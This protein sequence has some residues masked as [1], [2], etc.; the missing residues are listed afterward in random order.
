VTQNQ[1]TGDQDEHYRGDHDDKIKGTSREKTRE[2]GRRTMYINYFCTFCYFQ[3]A[4]SITTPVEPRIYSHCTYQHVVKHQTS[5]IMGCRKRTALQ[6]TFGLNQCSDVALTLTL[7]WMTTLKI[8]GPDAG[9]R[10]L[11][12]RHS[13]PKTLDEAPVFCYD[14]PRRVYS[15][16]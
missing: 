5:C 15:S 9:H 2:R 8:S 16:S 12:K 11:Q 4:L 14:N 3:I 6:S 13:N 7:R 1:Y 10:H